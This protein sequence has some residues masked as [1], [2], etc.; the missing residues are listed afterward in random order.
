MT[1]A[2][3]TTM[4]LYRAATRLLLDTTAAGEAALLAVVDART[5]QDADVRES[6]AAVTGTDYDWSL[7]PAGTPEYDAAF[8]RS[9][10]R[11]W[12]AEKALDEIAAADT[13][14][15]F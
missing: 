9:E 14:G 12:V 11:T 7:H 15:M 3:P 8:I 2:T 6:L 5:S 4:D 10:L 13:N 1:T